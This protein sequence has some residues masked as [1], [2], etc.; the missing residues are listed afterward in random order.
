MTSTFPASELDLFGALHNVDIVVDKKANM[1]GSVQ[2]NIQIDD[3]YDY[4][5]EKIYEQKFSIRD[6]IFY[7]L[8]MCLN[9]VAF[10]AQSYGII[11]E[12]NVKIL[13]SISDVVIK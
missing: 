5:I 9:N 2:Y 10:S 12:Y 1:D 7:T 4:K 6:S 3:V 11:N 13:F 8:V